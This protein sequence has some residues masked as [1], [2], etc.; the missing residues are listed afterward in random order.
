[1]PDRD[2]AN[3]SV[4][5]T[6]PDSV[7]VIR[8]PAGLRSLDADGAV[9]RSQVVAM[10]R[11]SGFDVV[12][13]LD[14]IPGRE[15]SG[16]G[17]PVALAVDVGADQ[18]AVVLSDR[19]GLW[20]WQLPPS[21]PPA[22]EPGS[23]SLTFT[24]AEPGP[25]PH[26]FGAIV[27][28]F[29][30]ALTLTALESHVRPGLVHLRGTTPSTWRR[31][32]AL[33]DITL[34]ANGPARILLLIHGTFSDTE[35]AYGMLARE[36]GLTFLTQ[37]LGEYDAVIGF[38]H[39]T[40]SVDPLTN[41]R[42]L[43]SRLATAHPPQIDIVSHSRGGLV[44]RSLVEQVIPDS[45]SAPGVENIVFVGVPNGGTNFVDKGRL[46]TFVDLYTNLL[47]ASAASVTGDGLA[48]VVAGGA[49]RGVSALVKYLV[50]HADDAVIPG[51]AAMEPDGQFLRE[52]NAT[53]P[54]QPA[55]GT[56]PWFVVGSD[57]HI[58][59]DDF[60]SEFPKSFALW[61]AENTVDDV[62][63]EGNDLVVDT[64]SMADIDT[65]PGGYVHDA[66]PFGANPVVHHLNYFVQREVADAL[67]F[68]L[69]LRGDRLVA[70]E[71]TPSLDDG[72]QIVIGG[73][74]FEGIPN[75]TRGLR[76]FGLDRG[77]PPRDVVADDS[78]TP[79]PEP[80]A[81]TVPA[82]VAAEMPA[83]LPVGRAVD[84][85]VM[86]SRNEI[87]IDP[88]MASD[89]G[90]LRVAEGEVF[91]VRVM[92]KKNATIDG[93]DTDR[94]MLPPGRGVSEVQF[95]V[96]AGAPGD[97]A[98][99]VVL[100]RGAKNI[101]AAL[102]LEAE[103]VAGDDAAARRETTRGQVEVAA[104]TS[105]VLD[106]SV[107]LEISEVE[108]S[109]GDV[110]FQYWL[111]LP[112]APTVFR[113][114]SAPLRDRAGFVAELFE[115]IERKWG[116]CAGDPGRFTRYLQDRGSDLFEQLFPQELQ[117]RLWNLRNSLTSII[118]LADEPYFP[119]E[120]V[121][122]KP[123]VGRRQLKPR[124]FAQY[125]LLRWQFLPF[126]ATATMRARAGK[127][128]AVCPDYVDPRYVLAES[129]NEA[130]F[131]KHK[132]NA[133]EIA[134]SESN[135][136]NVLRRG[137]FD[138]L[139]FSGHGAARTD[140]VAEAVI[141]LRGREVHG[142]FTRELLSATTVAENAHLRNDDGS[143]PLV[144]LNACQAG[145]GGEQL[146]SLGGFA[147]AFLEA[148]AHAVVACLWSVKQGPSRIF[149]ETLY[150]R[151]LSGDVIRDAVGHARDAARA[152][153]D[154]ATSLAFVVYARPDAT[155]VLD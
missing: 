122:L 14:V 33:D 2:F 86:L 9:P 120:L 80:E 8:R 39:P 68:W 17:A 67:A 132:L 87:D 100:E 15:L 111:R 28:R 102:T 26:G 85:R 70:P 75:S 4:R 110:K 138:I 71:V 53:Q 47:L 117:S 149:V 136:R 66:L 151:L 90:T 88:T 19:D 79:E 116:D 81:P 20:T 77:G 93:A 105:A 104:E 128:L 37:A 97:V 152:G 31:V 7:D 123:P 121:H 48:K 115:G 154:A 82:H 11:D 34:P 108:L 98:V 119:W 133:K 1:M 62:L 118:L 59:R 137:G 22:R 29:A 35:G 114:E 89:H 65:P 127:V 61:L 91:T 141:L 55:P 148:G 84:L 78:A 147:R 106:D 50:S 12:A 10:L 38:D 134:A 13:D 16:D 52:L 6:F 131:L 95:A 25:V 44:A 56:T 41:A 23:G 30:G 27:L 125:G 112:D 143:G 99:K 58:T 150:E 40:L 36:P 24:L 146:S 69:I 63:D 5:A 3:G 129:A 74:A 142:D 21:A 155:L 130:D 139:H 94:I 126:P 51:L 43:L 113:Y 64:E 60:P 153:G 92:A 57:F 49:I 83:E 46:V 45:E 42:D 72:A 103:A 76:D 32:D 144:V 107:W 54:G 101:A 145:I 109:G 96:I 135:V 73:G 140:D 18:R 124:F